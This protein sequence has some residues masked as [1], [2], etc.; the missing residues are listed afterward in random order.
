[1]SE[2]VIT[3]NHLSANDILVRGAAIER[4]VRN[5]GLVTSLQLDKAEIRLDQ[6]EKHLEH[7]SFK[8]DILIHDKEIVTPVEKGRCACC[9]VQ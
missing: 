4:R 8:L 7:I 2:P 3:T 5:V 9:A 6:I 1:M